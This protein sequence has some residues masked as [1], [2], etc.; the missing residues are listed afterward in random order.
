MASYRSGSSLLSDDA[1]RGAEGRTANIDSRF[2]EQFNSGSLSYPSSMG[3]MGS[4]PL[5]MKSAS[6][7]SSMEYALSSG[8]GC[9]RPV[10]VG[11]WRL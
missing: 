7:S 4:M 8:Y 1:R 10:V 3:W 6:G 2:M 11:R 9:V 5:P